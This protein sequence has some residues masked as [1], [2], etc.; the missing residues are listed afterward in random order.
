MDEQGDTKTDDKYE[1]DPAAEKLKHTFLSDP[2]F[3]L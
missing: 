3:R 2:F 1:N